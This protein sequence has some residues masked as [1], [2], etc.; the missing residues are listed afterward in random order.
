M[1]KTQDDAD[2][3]NDS[4]GEEILHLAPGVDLDLSDWIEDTGGWKQLDEEDDD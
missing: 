4:S 2:W 1:P 3:I